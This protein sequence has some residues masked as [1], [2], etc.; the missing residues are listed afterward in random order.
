MPLCVPLEVVHSV[1]IKSSIEVCSHICDNAFLECVGLLRLPSYTALWVV[2]IYAGFMVFLSC[3]L[4]PEG[5]S[6][7]LDEQHGGGDGDDEA[8]LVGNSHILWCC[9]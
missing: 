8:V 2:M 5:T 3:T 9:T 1:Q 4:M 7:P 6:G